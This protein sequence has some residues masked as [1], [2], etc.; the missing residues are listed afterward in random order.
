MSS[1]YDEIKRDI[2]FAH[3]ARMRIPALEGEVAVLKMRLMDMERVASEADR[4]MLGLAEAF[5]GSVPAVT[6]NVIANGI[7]N[8]VVRFRT[9]RGKVL[10]G[11]A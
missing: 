2:E 4:F 1:M 7:A 11:E 3:H 5:T 10:R 6:A 8:Q 9:M